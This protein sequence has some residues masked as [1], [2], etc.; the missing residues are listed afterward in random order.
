MAS[1]LKKLS[2]MTGKQFYFVCSPAMNV[3]A[4]TKI[5]RAGWKVDVVFL[6]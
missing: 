1:T 5:K 2:V 4:A 6:E 3:R